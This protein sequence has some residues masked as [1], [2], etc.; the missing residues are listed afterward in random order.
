LDTTRVRMVLVGLD[1]VTW[2]YV[3]VVAHRAF[4]G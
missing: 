2:I 4:F 1:A 3:A